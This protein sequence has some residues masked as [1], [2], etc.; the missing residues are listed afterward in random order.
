PVL[1]VSLKLEDLSVHIVRLILIQLRH[2]QIVRQL[3]TRS[4]AN[5]RRSFPS[6]D[7][8][9]NQLSVASHPVVC[10]IVK[11]DGLTNVRMVSE[12]SLNLGQFHAEAADLYLTIAATEKLDVAVFQ[13]ARNV[14]CSE[15][16][17]AWP[18]A[19]RIGDE[20]LARQRGMDEI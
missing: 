16:P 6:W 4:A 10:F 14:A 9:S 7:D 5:C 19:E 20:S 1:Q 11:N 3:V 17:R 8:I 15:Q 12:C 18:A 13:V 2:R